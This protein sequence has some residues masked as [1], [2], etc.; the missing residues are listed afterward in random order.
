[1]SGVSKK[2]TEDRNQTGYFIFQYLASVFDS[3]VLVAG[4]ILTPDT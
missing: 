2:M 4:C 3:A 1:L